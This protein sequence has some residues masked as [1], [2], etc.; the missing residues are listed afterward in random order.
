[1]PNRTSY[2]LPSLRRALAAAA[3][4]AIGPL[5]VAGAQSLGVTVDTLRTSCWSV[6]AEARA[7][8]T[9]RLAH[10]VRARLGLSEVLTWDGSRSAFV[11]GDLMVPAHVQYVETGHNVVAVATFE[12]PRATALPTGLP[13]VAANGAARREIAA[14][15]PSGRDRTPSASPSSAVAQ[16]A[17]PMEP[18]SVGLASRPL[19]SFVTVT[20]ARVV[21][22]D[23][24]LVATRRAIAHFVPATVAPQRSTPPSTLIVRG[25]GASV[26]VIIGRE[27][28]MALRFTLADST[29]LLP[30]V[31]APA[32]SDMSL[33]AAIQPIAMSKGTCKVGWFSPLDIADARLES[34]G[35]LTCYVRYGESVTPDRVTKMAVEVEVGHRHVTETIKVVP[36]VAPTYAVRGG[37]GCEAVADR[38]HKMLVDRGV[39]VVSFGIAHRRADLTHCER[40]DRI[41]PVAVGSLNPAGVYLTGQ[42][43]EAGV[44]LYSDARSVGPI[45]LWTTKPNGDPTNEL[46]E[47]IVARLLKYTGL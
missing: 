39:P 46:A 14:A 36:V 15:R 19:S 8:A 32:G 7:C 21:T 35:T 26:P 28:P 16:N 45:E 1:M 23:D 25:P 43:T 38:V 13:T 9:T 5:S 20:P 44:S 27:K 24:L 30:G 2:A 11:A 17:A 22:A 29:L 33:R 37:D 31:N 12:A 41:L 47:A 40:F 18:A 34:D 6:S 4:L 3:L 42:V 10:R